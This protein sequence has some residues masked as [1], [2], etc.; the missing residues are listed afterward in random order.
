MNHYVLTFSDENEFFYLQKLQDA[1]DSYP[2]DPFITFTYLHSQ[3]LTEELKRNANSLIPRFVIAFS[4][5]VFFSLLC[6]LI[7][8]DGTFY[9]DWVLSKPVL[10][11]LGVINAGMG[12]VT[13]IGI[14]NFCGNF[15]FRLYC[16]YLF[17]EF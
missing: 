3:T 13:G 12:I 16:L 6:S 10:S 15:P 2:F 8:V 7:F 17:T 1:L 14:T 9:V 4:I 5:L 11:L